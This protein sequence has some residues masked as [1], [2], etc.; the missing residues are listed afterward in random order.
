MEQAKQLD[1]DKLYTETDTNLFNFDTTEELTALSNETLGQTRAVEAMK[2]G[3]GVQ[4]EGYNIYALGPTGLGKRSIIQQFFE[5]RASHD[6]TPPDWVYVYNFKQRHQPNAI[7]LPPGRGSAFAK[8]MDTLVEELKS[9]LRAAFESD[10][11]R[12]R[13]QVLEQEYQDRQE[14]ALEELQGQAK[15]N[16]FSMLRTPGGLVFAPVKE[17][18]AITPEQFQAIPEEERKEIE[19]K[20]EELQGELQKILQQVPQYQKEIRERLKELNRGIIDYAVGGL[21]DDIRKKYEDIPEIPSYLDQVEADVIDN[22][23]DILPEEEESP[24]SVQNPLMALMARARGSEENS[25]KR[26]KVN[27]FVDNGK[28]QGA[29]VIYEDNPTY[30]NLIG[31]V[32]HVAQMGA[33]MTDF[34]LIRAGALHKANGGFLILDILKVLQN[35]YAWEAL[36]RALRSGTIRI[37]SIGQM[38]S[39]ISTISLEPEAIQL[40][41]KVALIGDRMLYYLLLQADP[42]FSELFKVQADFEESMERTAENQQMYARLIATLVRKY[43]LRPFDRGAVARII[44]HSARIAAD[45]ERL[46]INVTPISNLLIE[47]N[48]WAGEYGNGKVTAS[49]VEKAIGEQV[50]RGSRLRDREQEAILRDI[51]RI[52]TSGERIGQVNGL[53]VIQL[54]NYAFGRPSRISARVWMGKGNVINIE[55]E[56][57]MSGPIHSKGVL[58]LSGFMGARYAQKI[59][60]AVSASLVFEQS[61][62]GVEGDSASSAELYAL[63][64]ALAE[65]PVKQNF[66]VTGSVDQHGRVQAIGG[67]NEKIE[68][69][70]DICKAR[71]LTGD[72]GVII[73]A[74][75]VQHLMLRYDVVEAVRQGLFSI[76][77]I[78]NIDQGIEILT[79]IPA[80]MMDDE[81]KFPEGTINAKVM[82]RLE[83]FAERQKKL[84]A[85]GKGESLVAAQ[86][87]SK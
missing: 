49:D 68:G 78:E 37:E 45:A 13:R 59:P 6:P 23:E 28:T 2:L 24:A 44:E 29:P 8:D 5:S 21:I 52:D 74:S 40:D 33:L 15:A 79:G 3:I 35:P 56:V 70:F 10:E 53:S 55:R 76:Y 61:Y 85:E 7:Q 41:V 67:V 72:Q 84:E 39:M 50:Y 38:L 36:K 63:L 58:I 46:S 19:K 26:Y 71:G 87:N 81:G 65:V 82:R 47:S 9:A 1:A 11:Y 83:E 54:G 16:N 60:L 51:F 22:V 43:K 62:S 12:S 32:E 14:K 25:L 27:V 34:T 73:P 31:E 17:G 20:M 86:E 4:Q 75:N 48:Y 42:D 69:F 77:P 57:D 66:S 18:E 80:G 30:Q 64:S